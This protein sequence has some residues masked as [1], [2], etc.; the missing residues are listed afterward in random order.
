MQLSG[1]SDET[2]VPGLCRRGLRTSLVWAGV[3]AE[4]AGVRPSLVF[5]TALFKDG[6]LGSQ[7]PLPESSPSLFFDSSVKRASGWVRTTVLCLS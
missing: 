4:V 3:K 2:P 6:S 5:S 1:T 7:S